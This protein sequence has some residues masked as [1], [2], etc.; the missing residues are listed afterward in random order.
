[1]RALSAL[2]PLE[3]ERRPEVVDRLRDDRAAFFFLSIAGLGMSVAGLAGLVS[4]FRRGEAAWDRVELWRLRA[5]ARLSFTCVF[6]A[7]VIFSIFALTGDQAIAI[8]LTSAGIAGLYVIEVIMALRDR[9]NWPRRAWI[10]GALLPDGAFGLF[11]IVNVALGLTG[12]LEV[13]L[14]LRLI[15]PVNLFLLVLRS[16]EPPIR[17]S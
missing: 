1:M 13:G 4:A 12:L 10:P 15:H 6:L 5:I 2:V 9:L 14:L 7:L 8:R 3:M 16:F 11:N 17:S